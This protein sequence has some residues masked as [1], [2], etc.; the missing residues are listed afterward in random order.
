VTRTL[1]PASGTP[2]TGGQLATQ[3]SSPGPGVIGPNEFRVYQPEGC[4][5]NCFYVFVCNFATGTLDAETGHD[6]SLGTLTLT[7]SGTNSNP[8]YAFEDG[9]SNSTTQID[10]SFVYEDDGVLCFEK[11]QTDDNVASLIGLL[12]LV[13][14]V[15]NSAL[16]PNAGSFT[17]PDN[18]VSLN[19]PVNSCEL[20][21]S[22]LVTAVPRANTST[23]NGDDPPTETTVTTYIDEDKLKLT[24]TAAD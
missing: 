7:T 1:N 23:N 22:W 21:G 20:A 12:R 8:S 10:A 19:V 2:A 17:P 24:I 5:F 6:P 13:P 18:S 15:Q 3:A 11:T 16:I 4:C 14:I 9:T